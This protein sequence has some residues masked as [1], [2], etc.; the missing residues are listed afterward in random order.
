MYSSYPSIIH[1][2]HGC[3]N[4]LAEAI[5]AGEETLKPSQNTYDWLGSG[6]YFWENDNCSALLGVR[7]Q[8]SG[9]RLNP[10]SL[11]L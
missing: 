9:A 5:F 2:F 8:V 10:D 3:D 11:Y 1:G 4:D 6:I 7:N